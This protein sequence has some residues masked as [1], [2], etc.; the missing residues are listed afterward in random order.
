MWIKKVWYTSYMKKHTFF[1]FIPVGIAA[2]FIIVASI[3]RIELPERPSLP[4]QKKQE[5]QSEQVQPIVNDLSPA[6][7]PQ[8][9]KV[10]VVEF[11]DFQCPFCGASHQGV[12]EAL[13][14][15]KDKPVRFVFRQL[16]IFTIHPYAL[17]AANAALC[18]HEQKQYLA[19]HDLLFRNQEKIAPDIFITFAQNLGLNLSAFNTC[20]AE[21]KY[22]SI[23][24][25]D[26][27]DAESLGLT[28]TPTWF[29][30]EERIIGSLSE[31]D[32]KAII[33]T[34]LEK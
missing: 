26:L 4:S 19:M 8:D 30:N 33:D 21:K 20:V 29:I 11:L 14:T 25:K 22:Q 7:G 1:F 32:L 18:A 10:T 15:Y 27:S 16:P 2:L 28:G 5:F 6:F 9:A 12:M 23:I 31:N 13:Q 3:A 17:Q 34:Y 24:Q